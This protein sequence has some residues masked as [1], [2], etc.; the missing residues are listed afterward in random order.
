M[1][2]AH[3]QVKLL[4]TLLTVVFC[5]EQSTD[6]NNQLQLTIF[7][8]EELPRA[9]AVVNLSSMVKQN[10]PNSS[11]YFTLVQETE[12]RFSFLEPNSHFVIDHANPSAQILRVQTRVD[13]ES[14]CPTLVGVCTNRFL[15]TVTDHSPLP[16]E[17]SH[18]QHVATACMLPVLLI[19]EFNAR[20]SASQPVSQLI[21]QLNIHILDIN[22]NAPSWRSFSSSMVNMQ[23]LNSTHPIAYNAMNAPNPGLIPRMDLVVAEHIAIGTRLALPLAIDPD[24][25]PDNTT[26]GY[27]IESQTVS[28]AFV[29]DWDQAARDGTKITESGLWLR[30]N[31]DLNHDTQP[32]HQVIIYATDAGVPRRLTGHLLLNISVTDVNDHPPKFNRSRHLVW[33]REHEMIGS[34]VF[35]PQVHDAD[36]SDQSRLSFG[37]LPSTVASTRELFKI[38]PQTG[39]IT[40]QGLI[41]FEKSFQ[42]QLHIFVSDGK[43]TD[44]MELQVLVLNLNDHAPQIKL[45]SHLASVPKDMN[46]FHSGNR[47]YL[48]AQ[49]TIVIREN[50]PPNQLIATATVTDKDVSAQI[51]AEAAFE[52]HEADSGASGERQGGMFTSPLVRKSQT[53]KPICNVDNDQFVMESLDLET[54]QQQS[55]ERFRF[56]I[57]LAGKSLDREK[58]NRILL[59]VHCHDEDTMPPMHQFPHYSPSSS[60]H[61]S[62][63]Y[64][65]IGRRSASASLLIVVTDEND[66]P[67]ILVGPQVAK[68]PENAPIDTLVMRI[69]ATD[70][71]DPHSLAGTA[72]LRYHLTDEPLILLTKSATPL[73]VGSKLSELIASSTVSSDQFP[74]QPWFHLNPVNGDLKTLVSFDRELVQSITL[75]IRV[76]DGGDLNILGKTTVDPSER[77]MNKDRLSYNTVNGT[78]T[79]EILDVND[80]LPTFSQQL[81]EFNLSEDSRPPV[82]V[83]RVNVTDCDVDENNRL[84]EF[85]LQSSMPNRRPDISA[86]EGILGSKQLNKNSQFISWFSVSKT[87]ELYVRMPHFTQTGMVTSQGLPPDDYIPLDREKNEIIVLDIFARDSGSPALTGSAQI[88]IRVLDVNDHAPEWEF[89]RPQHRL[90]NF[91][92]DA[93]VG[94]RV[95]RLI[96]HDPDEGPRGRITY[97]IL[98]GNE[99]GQFE[100][101]SESGWIYLAQPIDYQNR[102]SMSGPQNQRMKHQTWQTRSASMIRLYVQASD[103]GDPPRTSSSVLDI[104]IQRTPQIP[105]QMQSSKS[106]ISTDQSR[107]TKQM[108]F[109]EAGSDASPAEMH[110]EGYFDPEKPAGGLLLS[111]DFLTL[112]AMITATLAALLLIFI[113]F[114]VIRCRKLKHNQPPQTQIGS[115]N[116]TKWGTPGHSSS[117]RP[118]ERTRRTTRANGRPGCFGT[119][120][121]NC[122]GG[123]KSAVRSPRSA[124]NGDRNNITPTDTYYPV[125]LSSTLSS[126][127]PFSISE[128]QGHRMTDVHSSDILLY[129]TNSSLISPCQTISRLAPESTLNANDYSFLVHS[130]CPAEGVQFDG[131]VDKKTTNPS[132]VSDLIMDEK[133]SMD[134]DKYVTTIR[135]DR[136]QSDSVYTALSPELTKSK[137]Q[138]HKL[139]QSSSFV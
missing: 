91:S 71:D 117:R 66:S 83:G 30:V 121:E 62:G 133:D 10:I 113:L 51:R 115:M 40:V 125:H 36:S 114:V 16:Y 90:V 112:V 85:W 82:R 65:P 72:G 19:A 8:E 54:T 28:D 69:H 2:L 126:R 6:V 137:S 31:K 13:R 57:A 129:S 42:H 3:I 53:L 132:G 86:T 24:A 131:S 7:M 97:S 108:E 120:M 138:S 64:M 52:S 11:Q 106:S 35:Q 46:V 63:L 4:A 130:N 29:L 128:Q 27:G 75:P 23:Q 94:N 20:N 34:K 9:S 105:V 70:A 127:Q 88:L 87:G 67:P 84:L 93:A 73:S 77:M 17:I 95:T 50:G 124:T 100:L 47:N 136:G 135:I 74:S 76:N 38:N 122:F 45:Y 116:G 109:R 61:Q 96:A 99:A 18:T 110:S 48:Q 15:G 58:Q 37:F 103:Q 26:A 118:T 111:S 101:D 139:C 78:V 134:K 12:L 60:L 1:L 98:S 39:E 107:H 33:V 21:V 56:K 41:D 80:C 104:L 5:K 81:Y 43:W 55:R 79:I 123:S 44:E 14:V 92:A 89:P 25:C 68:L 32:H 22:D 59:Q 102:M 119:Y 49:L